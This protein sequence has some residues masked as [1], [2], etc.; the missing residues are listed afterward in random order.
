MCF[1]FIDK[2]TQ[3]FA[4]FA[5]FE[6]AQRVPPQSVTVCHS[7]GGVLSMWRSSSLSCLRV[8]PALRARCDHVFTSVIKKRSTL[9]VSPILSARRG[10]SHSQSQ[11]ATVE[12]ASESGSVAVVAALLFFAFS[13]KVES[14]HAPQHANARQ[15]R[16]HNVIRDEYSPYRC[17]R[18]L[19]REPV[20]PAVW[21]S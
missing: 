4:R 21:Q 16:Q 20:S 6:C 15:R 8:L 11:S 10:C 7:G 5:D 19:K 13:K 3:H 9:H 14:A 1:Y 2:E 12:R 18:R 17:S